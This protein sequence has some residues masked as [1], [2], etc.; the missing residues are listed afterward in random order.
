M[1]LIVLDAPGEKAPDDLHDPPRR[2]ALLANELM[3]WTLATETTY[4]RDKHGGHAKTSQ[5]HRTS[6]RDMLTACFARR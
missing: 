5:S 6:S 3:E 2:K 1:A 4:R